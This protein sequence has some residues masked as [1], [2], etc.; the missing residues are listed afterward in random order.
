LKFLVCTHGQGGRVNF[1]RFCADVLYGRPLIEII[2][3][4]QFKTENYFKMSLII[5]PKTKS[6][7]FS[8]NW[9]N[10]AS[11]WSFFPSNVADCFSL[12]MCLYCLYL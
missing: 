11:W 1:S 8:I 5:K 7:L 6:L 2:V 10:F 12:Q 3:L 4:F 9:R